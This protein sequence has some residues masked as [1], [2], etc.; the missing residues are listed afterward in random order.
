MV[1]QTLDQGDEHSVRYKAEMISTNEYND[2]EF[3]FKPKIN[4]ASKRMVENSRRSVG[5]QDTCERLY[6][7]S[8]PKVVK[9]PVMKK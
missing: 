8:K 6:E 9:P 4:K 2:Q 5:E 7:Q 3:P 1:S